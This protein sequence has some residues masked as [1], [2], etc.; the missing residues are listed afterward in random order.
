MP[1]IRSIAL[2][3]AL[4]GPACGPAL[5][6]TC[7]LTVLGTS[8]LDDEACAVGTAG[9]VTTVS[10]GT[11]GTIR[12]RRSLMSASLPGGGTPP[13][14]RRA[15]TTSFGRVVTSSEGDDKTCYFNQKAVLCVE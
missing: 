13:G 1:M 11:G 5:A 7:S 2:A 15:G 6:A 4:A 9:G 12:I 3:V 10:V 8:V 14:R